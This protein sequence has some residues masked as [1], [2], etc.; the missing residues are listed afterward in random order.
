MAATMDHS[1]IR[2][3]A[4]AFHLFLAGLPR[5]RSWVHRLDARIKRAEDSPHRS[6]ASRCRFGVGAFRLS[7]GLVSHPLGRWSVKAGCSG[8]DFHL[9]GDIPDEAGELTSDRDAAF[10]LGHFS[11]C[12]ELAKA[13]REAKLR[14]PGEVADGFGLT[15]L[16]Y[17]DGA[18]DSGIE[19]VGPGRL[20]E[21][22]S[23]VLIACFG[24]GA[25]LAAG[26]A[27]RELRGDQP[28]VLHQC[29]WVSKAAQ[30]A[31]LCDEAGGR[32]EIK[33]AQTH[34][35]IDDTFHAPLFT[36]LAQCLRQPLDAL[37]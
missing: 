14:S 8:R 20:D 16:A 21:D 27:G 26:I 22:A 33:A 15:F 10:V 24:D 31:K 17:L 30:I 32:G 29:L 18:A 13:V 23:G 25:A 5:S 36:L 9:P 7:V 1:D 3:L 4:T 19:A 37:M 12:I 34:Q 6:R 11:P 35:R 28:Q 2:G